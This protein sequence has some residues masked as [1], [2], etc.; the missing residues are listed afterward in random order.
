MSQAAPPWCNICSQS[1]PFLDPDGGR[2]G[3]VC[4]NC[5]ASSRQRALVYALGAWLGMGHGPLMDWRPIPDLS[6]LEASGRGAYP[7]FLADKFRYVNTEFPPAGQTGD[8][9]FAR[10]A[11]LEHLGYPDATL[12]VILAADVF[13]HVRRDDRAFAEARRVLKPSGALLFTVPYDPERAETLVRVRVE[14]DADVPLMEPEYHG[15]GGRSL[16]Y[17]TYGRDLPD[18]LRDHGF[19]VGLWNVEE[20]ANAITRQ[21]VFLCAN[22][23]WIDLGRLVRPIRSASRG[24]A[25]TAPLLPFRL[26]V[27]LK[28]N[29]RAA[30][31]LLAELRARFGR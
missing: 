12:D 22:G 1:G 16:A 13:E 31:Q 2:E 18:R 23:N 14:G 24:K 10:F 6:I 3:L 30:R 26:L 21:R 15:G 20:P 11:D 29:L 7:R 28:Y 4:A 17:R 9:P 19:T 8:E 25:R 27:V 5:S